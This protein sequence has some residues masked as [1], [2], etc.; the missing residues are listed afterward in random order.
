M[1][2]SG[3]M[4]PPIGFPVSRT[5]ELEKANPCWNTDEQALDASLCRNIG[6]GQFPKGNRV[7]GTGNKLN[8]I[9]TTHMVA[10]RGS[11]LALPLWQQ[12]PLGTLPHAS[13][14]RGRYRARWCG[15]KDNCAPW[16]RLP[17]TFVLRLS[18]A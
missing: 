9:T 6:P 15:V 1:E 14:S 17:I 18:A 16:C 4:G 8:I 3:P 5:M 11:M 7:C 2:W 13:H 12:P 10:V